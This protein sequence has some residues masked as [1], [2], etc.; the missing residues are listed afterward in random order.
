PAIQI[1]I[2]DSSVSV[3]EGEAVY[4]AAAA[5]EVP[6]EEL[7]AVI[8]EAFRTTAGAGDGLRGACRRPPPHGRRQPRRP[9]PRPARLRNAAAGRA[10][11]VRMD[12][13]PARADELDAV[14]A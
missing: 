2:F 11:A 6:E 13:R 7:E 8:G 9:P 12:I 3:G 5:A 4:L 14:G 10:V 1:V